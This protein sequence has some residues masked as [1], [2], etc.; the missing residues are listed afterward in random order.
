MLM[1]YQFTFMGDDKNVIVE[2]ILDFVQVFI[3][4]DQN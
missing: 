1:K 2:K 4:F 3:E